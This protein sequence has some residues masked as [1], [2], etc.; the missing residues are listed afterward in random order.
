MARKSNLIQKLLFLFGGLLLANAVSAQQAPQYSQYIFNELVINPAYAGSKEVL[1]INLT[2]RSQWVGLEGAPTTQSLSID[3][4]TQNT[5]IGWGAHL[6]NDRIGAQSQTGAYA[7][8]S[9][10]ISLSRETKLALGLAGGVS[11]YVLD[12]NKLNTGNTI[13]DQALPPGREV[14]ILPDAKV[15]LF[16]N[17]ERYYAGLTAANLI[18]FKSDNLLITTPRRHYFLSMG[19]TFDLNRNLRLKPSLLIKE[20]FKSPANLDLNAFLLMYDRLW[21][22]ASYRTAV[23]VFTDYDMK[24]LAKRNAVALIAQVYATPRLR[25]GYAYDLSLSKLNNYASHEVSVGYMF[26]K[27]RYGRIITPRNL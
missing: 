18:P 23:P 20:D 19:Y 24:Q 17:T 9:A 25:I 4:A 12:G 10:R 27:M 1:N 8:I 13:P 21:V 3:G 6:I 26:Y 22:G 11:Q 5:N 16:L 2:H 15:G 14:S 7:N